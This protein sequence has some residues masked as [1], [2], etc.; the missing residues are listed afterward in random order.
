MR[1]TKYRKTEISFSFLLLQLF[2]Q[3]SYSEIKGYQNITLIKKHY[4]KLINSFKHAINETINITD[5]NQITSLFNILNNGEQKIKSCDNF[6]DID[7]AFITIQT[8]MILQ[9]LGQIPNR[10]REKNIINKKE[11]WKLNS[12]RQIQYVQ[13][14]KHK[15][16]M[17]FKLIQEKYIDRFGD[18]SDFVLLYY[19]ECNNEYDK[20][21]KLLKDKHPDIYMEI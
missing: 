19:S 2:G 13:N 15:E 8:K 12:L 17:V 11:N 7:Q 18:W 1:E 14:T 21:I 9:L 4:I 3:K 20:L 16:L 6:N 10:S 5:K